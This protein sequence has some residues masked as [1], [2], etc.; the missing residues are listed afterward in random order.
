M[1]MK[2]K[3]IFALLLLL[4]GLLYAQSSDTPARASLTRYADDYTPLDSWAAQP[5]TLLSDQELQLAFLLHINEVRCDEDL[6]PLIYNPTLFGVSQA[7]NADMSARNTLSH[8]GADGSSPSERLSEAGY[9]WRQSAENIAAGQL[10][11]DA[12]FESWMT[13]VG[14]RQNMLNPDL[15][16]MGIAYLRDTSSDYGSYW[17]LN[18]AAPLR[19]SAEPPTCDDL[20]LP[21]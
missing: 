17:T 20:N 15:R 16:E 14:H 8:I 5:T 2:T 11:V 3:V 7:H 1:H 9:D 10:S 13:S 19:Q 18:L 21:R 12:V 6:T 4:P